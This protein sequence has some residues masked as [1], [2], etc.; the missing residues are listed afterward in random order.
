MSNDNPLVSIMMP[1][2]NA[3]RFLRACL[4][5]ISSQTYTNWELWAVSDHSNDKSEAILAEYA[6]QD[7]RIHWCTNNQPKGIIH[8]LRVAFSKSKGTLITRMDADDLMP[9]NKLRDFVEILVQSRK[10][11]L[12]TGFVTYFSKLDL[13]DGYLRY[14]AWLND[15]QKNGDP[16]R[17][18][19]QECVIPSPAWMVYRDDFLLAGGFS[20]DIYPE[21]YD[22]AFRF[23]AAGLR[24]VSTGTSVHL[25]RDHPERTSRNDPVYAEQTY[26]P[27]KVSHFA[28]I[29]FDPDSHL[30]LWGAGKKGKLLA[31]ALASEG[32]PFSWTCNTATKWGKEI[33]GKTMLNPRE[34][35]GISNPVFL[36][37]VS[38][39]KDKNSILMEWQMEGLI[40]GKDY[41]IFI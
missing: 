27:L 16:F 39:P 19:Y 34:L 3:E 32:L 23:Y 37:A 20:S 11:V 29:D 1:V 18:I 5:S 13:K 2:Y 28:Q 24:V 40:E 35:H 6:L 10:G 12:A 17:G 8:A 41:F 15:L 38:G 33:Y 25:W 26:F 7:A 9:A 22:L 4:D 21:D 31:K 30:I 14:A 36:M